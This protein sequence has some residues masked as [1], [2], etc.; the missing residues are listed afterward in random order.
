MQFFIQE[1]SLKAAGNLY[2]IIGFATLPFLWALPEAIMTYELSTRYPDNSGGMRWV[3]EAFGKKLGLLT[4]SVGWF[5]G[6]ATAASYPVLFLSYIHQQYYSHLEDL[7]P[8]SRY[9]ILLAIT[10]T[11]LLVNYRGLHVVGN[12]T[13]IIFLI[14]IAPFLVMIIIG[15]PEVDPERWLETPTGEIVDFDD[16]SLENSSWWP[17]AYV[18]GIAFRPYINNLFWNFNGFDQGSHLSEAD[19]C[20]PKTLRWGIAGSFIL[21]CS[22]YMLPILVATG[23]TDIEQNE[24]NAGSFARAGNEIAGRWLG[25]WI[26][27]A[28]G[29]SLLAQFFAECSCDSMQILGMAD[30]DLLPPVFKTRSKYNTPTF[31]LLLALGLIVLLLP[32]KFGVIIELSNFAFVFQATCEFS[33]FAKLRIRKGDGSLMRKTLYSLMIAPPLLLNIT[34]MLLASYATYICGAIVMAFGV[35]LIYLPGM[36]QSSHQLN[37]PRR[38]ASAPQ[39]GSFASVTRNV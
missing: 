6:V 39:L 27:F 38:S 16:D 18:S 25:N 33:A 24:W 9:F 15:F 23:A 17:F 10:S 21:V 8:L 4:G 5:S 20:T 14:S 36:I 35:L 12:V 22:V 1:P 13:I 29:L 7:D 32:L 31:G 30:K 28:A 26:V 37:R 34:I 2:T 3:S 19:T 11:L